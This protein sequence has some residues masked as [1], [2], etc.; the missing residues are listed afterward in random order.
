[1]HAELPVGPAVPTYRQAAGS[2]DGG[3]VG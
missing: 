3:D 2:L 1:V